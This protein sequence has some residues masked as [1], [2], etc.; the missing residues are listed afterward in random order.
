MAADIHPTAQQ[1][2]FSESQELPSP[3]MGSPIPTQFHH[4]EGMPPLPT[5]SAKDAET[6]NL[7]EETTPDQAAPNMQDDSVPD[8]NMDPPVH[9]DDIPAA[10]KG[11]PSSKKT[12]V[13]SKWSEVPFKANKT[14]SKP[15]KRRSSP[16]KKKSV[17]YGDSQA[18]K[19]K[20]DTTIKAT[21]KVASKPEPSKQTKKKILTGTRIISPS[22][23]DVICG[24]GGHSNNH[25]GN[26][27]FRD[28]VR[29]M[30]GVYR[31]AS[32]NPVRG[33]SMV[34]KQAISMV[35]NS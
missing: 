17:S 22:D 3:T 18:S 11:S 16:R 32:R 13:A 29:Q 33:S 19:S 26:V 9:D 14:Q 8:M 27:R 5:S 1:L 35:S 4:D 34:S 23:K 31:E 15:P 30:R 24:R 7:F 12:K 20:T 25:V 2:H 21:K 28:E 10:S 6:P